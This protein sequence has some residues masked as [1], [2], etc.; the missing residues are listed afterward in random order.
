MTLR[1]IAVLLASGLAGAISSC[2]R[3]VE[4]GL[5]IIAGVH[6]RTRR[7]AGAS[8]GRR[9][10]AVRTARN[11]IACCLAAAVA[12][13]P[14]PEPARRTRRRPNVALLILD[15]VGL[16]ALRM[17]SEENVYRADLAKKVP[18][19]YPQTPN[20]DSLAASGVRFTQARANPTCSASRAS[21]LTGRYAFRHGIGGLVRPAHSERLRRAET[22]EL[23]VGPGNEEVTLA[24]LARAA[25]YETLFCGKYHLAL[26]PDREALGGG[27]GTGWD[28][29]RDVAGFDRYWVVW[30]NLPVR[31]PPEPAADAGGREHPPGYYNFI[32]SRDGEVEQ[33]V[34]EYATTVQCDEALA[35]VRSA[36]KPWFLVLSFSAGHAPFD[37]PP[38]EL[39]ATEHYVTRAHDV[40]RARSERDVSIAVPSVWPFY[41][42]ILEAMDRELGRFLDELD[43]DGAYENT[44]FVVIGDN[45]TPNRVVE[46]ALLREDLPLGRVT[47][48]LV[49][50]RVERFKH[51]VWESG[52]RVPLIVSGPIVAEPGRASDALVD[53][54]DV[55]ATL[56]EV[57]GGPRSSTPT[58]GVDLDPILASRD[59]PGS[60]TFA[61]VERFQPNGNPEAIVYDPEDMSTS[62][63][64]RRG[65]VLATDRG[66]F[67]LVRNLD[68]D[69]DPSDKLFQL[70]D[71]T[72][73]PVDPWEL[74]PLDLDEEENAAMLDQVASEMERLLASEVR[75]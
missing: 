46:S 56:A 59:A 65:F 4:R 7:R 20:L 68:E 30:D 49:R 74:A 19:A 2:E 34:G 41:N 48:Q 53:S 43:R 15:D 21:I 28:H 51:S 55:F 70:T 62:N 45:G 23:G 39:I 27:P 57:F 9:R 64:W 26:L 35:L 3:P 31:P 5:A 24:H 6:G 71:E 13:T 66:R 75:D 44:I 73:A 61:Y 25:G 14:A 50:D 69:L 22:V 1:A 17:Y 40:L 72:G 10:A 36:V 54:T 42:A 67:K 47:S 11:L 29:V 52:V 33:R 12:C 8:G 60:R 16:D 38:E 58:D 63:Q 37:L 18:H 32:A